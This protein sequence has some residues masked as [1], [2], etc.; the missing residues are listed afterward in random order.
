MLTTPFTPAQRQTVAFD[1]LRTATRAVTGREPPYAALRAVGG[2]WSEATLGYLHE[3]TCEDPLTGL[4]S[5]PHL[6]SRVGEL[7]RDQAAGASVVRD[8]QVLL[9]LDTPAPPLGGEVFGAALRTARL[10]DTVRTV[11]PG[12]LTTGRVGRERV[13]VLARRD[14]RLDRRLA[15]VRTL[16]A[17]VTPAVRVWVEPLPHDGATAAALLDE[18]ARPTR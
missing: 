17:G 18:L 8:H 1:A 15:L 7:Y 10:A 9:V 6:R 12:G 13:A 16:L 3:V 4:A 2:G 14:G 5:L 11:F